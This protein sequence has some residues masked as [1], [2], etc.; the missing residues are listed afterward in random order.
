LEIISLLN[1]RGVE[2]KRVLTYS[3]D[4]IAEKVCELYSI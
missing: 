3:M 1:V 4:D 2:Y